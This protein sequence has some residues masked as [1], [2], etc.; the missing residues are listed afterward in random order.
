[1]KKILI[2]NG[3]V[4]TMNSSRQTLRADVLTEGDKIAEIAP[5]IS[6]HAD[7]II[8]ASGCAVIPGLVQS[9]VHLTQRLFQGLADDMQLMDWLKKRIWPLEAAH[10][11]ESN[12]ISAR[13]AIAEMIMGGT[14]SIIDMGTVNHT[15][16]LF[17]AVR[18]SGIR[19]MVG[20]CMM[21]YGK[22]VP[23]GLMENTDDSINESVRL[24][25]KYHGTAD[26]RLQ[27][28]FAPRFV[29]SCTEG[30]LTKIRDIARD[31][32]L[33]IH[34]HA[35]E[36]QGEISIVE[37]ITG[38]K[39]IKYL[40]KL[41]LTGQNLIL[42]HC[43]WLD[44]EEKQIL[45]DTGTHIAHCPSSNMKL[46][47]GTAPI[48]ELLEMGCRISLASDGAP[49]G[50]NMDI[51]T[52]MR[53]AALL[54]KVHSLNPTVMPAEKVFEMAT[55]GGADAM[56]KKDRLGS[57]EKGKL[58]DIAVVKLNTPHNSPTFGRDITAQ[59]VYSV[60]SSD[61]QTVIINGRMVMKDRRLLT[62]DIDEILGSAEKISPAVIDTYK[63][64]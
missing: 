33:K 19:A 32:N 5:N 40:H 13:L 64:L 12:L 7:E 60:R 20:K 8:D 55:L 49:C 61:V 62:M 23:T 58:A 63:N 52:E 43:I 59:M 34:T 4:V 14:T 56:G 28:A 30:L 3:S 22:N 47:S 21:D 38:L 1:M 17:E 37:K 26:G 16:A 11:Y 27:Y 44:A 53:H 46:A 48:P 10:T 2:K 25:D 41:G 57:L 31:M 45:A 42:A 50:N 6:T 39:N 51:F 9:H 29:V 18:E 24:A 54:Q 15:E 35:S 36:N